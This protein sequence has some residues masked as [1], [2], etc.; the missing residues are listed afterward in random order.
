MTVLPPQY[1]AAAELEAFLGDPLD[2]KTPFSFQAIVEADEG[3]RFPNEFLTLLNK[4]KVGEFYI[5]LSLGGAQQSFESMLALERVVARRDL[6]TA[7]AHGITNLSAQAV[8]IGGSVDQ[9]QQLVQTIREHQSVSFAVT[10]AEHGSDLLSN[11]CR[12]EWNG[13]DGSLTGHKWLIG[14]IARSRFATVLCRT[15][16]NGG[17]RGFSLILVDLEK[18]PPC[19]LVVG[20][21]VPTVGLRGVEIGEIEFRG[22]PVNREQVIGVLGGG[23]EL[24]LKSMQIT[25]PL[26][27]GAGLSLGV[28]ETALRLVVDFAV[29]RN[30]YGRTA[31]EIPHVR[32]TLVDAWCDLQLAEC[33]SISAMRAFHFIPEQMSL[34]SAVV[35]SLVPTLVDETLQ[36]LGRVLGARHF[37]RTGHWSGIFQK[38]VRDHQIV[39][40]F[41]GSTAVNLDALSAQ[42]PSVLAAESTPA[43]RGEVVQR[44]WEQIF[45]IHTPVVPFEPQRLAL[46][47]RGEDDMLTA[48]DCIQQRLENDPLIGDK[49]RLALVPRVSLVQEELHSLSQQFLP[50]AKE[51]LASRTSE[52]LEC[53]VRYSLIVAASSCLNFWLLNRSRQ[54]GPLAEGDWV[55]L[56][57][58]R[59]LRRLRRSGLGLPNV[60]SESTSQYL[61]HCYRENLMFSQVPIRLPS[62]VSA[63]S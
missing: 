36:S 31:W 63:A 27:A 53:A 4:H 57:L 24:V 62:T 54:M 6:T 25:R 26:F 28:A 22:A 52:L 20:K 60:G 18:L 34:L 15:N 30:I 10:E 41:D 49:L 38:L 12:V 51:R 2:S 17:P 55:V 46:H 45:Q 48:I 40:V 35:K 14:A 21:R 32:D 1:E 13:S 8:W 58:D 16:Q 7:L 29:H 39:S 50:T 61:M 5:P 33:L 43:Q 47:A 37:L 19:S 3:A 42:L 56:C 11:E 9:Q 23:I 59:I 44:R